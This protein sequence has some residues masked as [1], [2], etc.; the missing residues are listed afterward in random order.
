MEKTLNRSEFLLKIDENKKITIN[1]LNE[2]EEEIIEKKII[3]KNITKFMLLS[4]LKNNNFVLSFSQVE[5][6]GR[7]FSFHHVRVR[8][9]PLRSKGLIVLPR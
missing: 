7:S 1:I 9:S 8:D 3:G 5:R 6:E 4:R 2:E